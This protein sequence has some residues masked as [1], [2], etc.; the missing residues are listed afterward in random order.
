MLIF[1]NDQILPCKSRPKKIL[2]RYGKIFFATLVKRSKLALY[3][4][5]VFDYSPSLI[6]WPTNWLFFVPSVSYFTWNCPYMYMSIDNI[7]VKFRFQ[8]NLINSGSSNISIPTDLCSLLKRFCLN[9]GF[10]SSMPQY[11]KF[12]YSRNNFSINDNINTK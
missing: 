4:F 9:S 2:K 7:P 12:L 10:L 8:P 11:D 1:F 3:L 5:S 6:E